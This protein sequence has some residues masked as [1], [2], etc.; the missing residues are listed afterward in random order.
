MR[1]QREKE[2]QISQETLTMA[3]DNVA[4]TRESI[5][6]I[7]DS[8]TMLM[9]KE[10]M[11]KDRDAKAT[12]GRYPEPECLPGKHASARPAGHAIL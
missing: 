6:V 5:A 9:N 7:K 12:H 2:M 10:N 8:I 4:V 3:K 1:T 11:E